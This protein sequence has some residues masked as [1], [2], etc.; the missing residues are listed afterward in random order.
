MHVEQKTPLLQ[1]WKAG[2][3]ATGGLAASKRAPPGACCSAKAGAAATEGLDDGEQAPPGGSD[4]DVDLSRL[5]STFS[6]LL[7]HV[8]MAAVLAAAAAAPPP[9]PAAAAPPA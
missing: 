8:L 6:A 3:A 2:E 9:Q 1:L 7:I 4:E 5:G